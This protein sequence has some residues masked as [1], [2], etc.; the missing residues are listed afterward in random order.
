MIASI[1]FITVLPIAD[2]KATDVPRPP[3]LKR[4]ISDDWANPAG[5]TAAQISGSG[6]APAQASGGGTDSEG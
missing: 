6:R 4:A 3:G 1:F 5:L 2:V